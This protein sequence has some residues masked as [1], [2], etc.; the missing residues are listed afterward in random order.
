M[1]SYCKY[2]YVLFLSAPQNFEKQQ[3]DIWIS[4]VNSLIL[5]KKIITKCIVRIVWMM[6]QIFK[7]LNREFLLYAKLP[8]F[9]EIQPHGQWN[10]EKSQ[11]LLPETG[12]KWL[13]QGKCFFVE[14]FPHK[15][16]KSI[17]LQVEPRFPQF[18]RGSSR[19]VLIKNKDTLIWRHIL[20]YE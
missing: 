10:R 9:H 20:F 14:I 6:L 16:L 12:Q 13:F 4:L 2:F 7:K 15:T 18:L 5:K 1:L 19:Y 11:N 8:N 17:I 3:I